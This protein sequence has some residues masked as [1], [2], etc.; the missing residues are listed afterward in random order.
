M[1]F[2]EDLMD[3]ERSGVKAY[4]SLLKMTST[5]AGTAQLDRADGASRIHSTVQN[6][7]RIMGEISGTRRTVGSSSVIL[8]KLA[9]ED[10]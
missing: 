3:S 9:L 6:D 1:D 8:Q 5:R 4:S 2:K 7:L 10:V